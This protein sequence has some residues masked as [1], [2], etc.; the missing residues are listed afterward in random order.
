MCCEPIFGQDLLRCADPWGHIC[1]LDP[2]QEGE[3][4]HW[5]DAVEPL[6]KDDDLVP[7][8]LEELPA[9]A[10]PPDRVCPGVV[11]LTPQAIGGSQGEH[12]QGEHDMHPD[13]ALCFLRWMLQVP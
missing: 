5:K 3:F 6:G 9:P 7:V 13:G 10:L 4:G 11:W 12:Q 2:Q 1:E 8:L